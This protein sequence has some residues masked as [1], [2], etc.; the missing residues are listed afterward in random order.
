MVAFLS[1]PVGLVPLLLRGQI[2]PYG[3]ANGAMLGVRSWGNG[4]GVVEECLKAAY[5]S[6]L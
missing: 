4:W 3:L 6:A 2:L 5:Y 1:F